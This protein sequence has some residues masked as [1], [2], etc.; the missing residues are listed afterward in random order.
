MQ[1]SPLFSVIIR[2]VAVIFVLCA[3]NTAAFAVETVCN[4]RM[5]GNT[6]PRGTVFDIMRTATKTIRVFVNYGDLVGSVGDNANGITYAIGA[7]ASGGLNGCNTYVDITISPS[8]T[9]T[10]GTITVTLYGV[11]NSKTCDFQ[12]RIIAQPPPPVSPDE[13]DTPER[14][15]ALMLTPVVVSAPTDPD[16]TL[17][18]PMNIAF[19]ANI[20]TIAQGAALNTDCDAKLTYYVY[21]STTSA[22]LSNLS[23]LATANDE[24]ALPA[25]VLR[26][27]CTKSRNGNTISCTTIVPQGTIRA[28]NTVYYKIGKRITKQ[29]E[30]DP[31]VF[32]TAYNFV[33]PNKLPTANAGSNQSIVVPPTNSVLT[34]TGTDTD[35]TIT[36]YLWTQ[37]SGPNNATIASATA[38][39]TN[40]TGL[41]VGSYV[42]N[43]RVT[44]NSGGVGNDTKTLTCTAPP[45][46]LPDLRGESINQPI[47]GGLNGNVGDGTFTYHRLA[48]NFCT[49]LPALST[50]AQDGSLPAA[51]FA[52]VADKRIMKLNYPL[53]TMNL[54]YKNY[55][56]GA[57]GA[58]F[59]VQVLKGS[60]TTPL[61]PNLTVAALA[62]GATANVAYSTRGTAV[63]Y[64]F[65]G[66]DPPETDLRYC[67]VRE[68]IDH[69]FPATLERDGITL[70]VDSGSTITE[71]NDN[72][73][74]KLF[75]GG[76]VVIIGN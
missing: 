68:E 41:V 19:T 45:V 50:Y 29:G 75:V 30:T 48:E 49:S 12:V 71:S 27:T 52:S 62:A 54:A 69:T 60:T 37:T 39:T 1:N 65:P 17:T 35:G 76:T 70:K 53:P 4:L 56:T 23:N 66:F 26:L 59:Q 38:A 34:G 22:S 31:Y 16:Q 61:R 28:G 21:Y 15:L 32:S 24:F 55:G 25:G 58:G 51:S 3:L 9:S 36:G 40:I 44:D 42:F 43:L 33:A 8:A 74:S 11:A 57:T 64:R 63:V 47:Y 10:L 2:Y 6:R 14:E 46:Q 73:N 18:H 72:N 7:K 20:F 5:D 13:C 67:Y